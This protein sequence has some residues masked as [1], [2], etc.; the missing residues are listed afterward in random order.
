MRSSASADCAA[1]HLLLV[2][3]VPEGVVTW[4][5]TDKGTFVLANWPSASLMSVTAR[6]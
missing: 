4:I 6:L 1:Y 2:V 3:E 5:S